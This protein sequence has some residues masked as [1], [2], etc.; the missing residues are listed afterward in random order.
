[1]I[2]KQTFLSWTFLKFENQTEIV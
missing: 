2:S 1:M